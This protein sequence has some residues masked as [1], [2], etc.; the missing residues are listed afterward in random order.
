MDFS[1]S[2]T[3]WKLIES[4]WVQ[5]KA[6]HITCSLQMNLPILLIKRERGNILTVVTSFPWKCAL[7]MKWVRNLHLSMKYHS[8]ATL[9]LYHRTWF[10]NSLLLLNLSHK[11]QAY[12]WVGL[13]I[14][15][16][17]QKFYTFSKVDSERKKYLSSF[18]FFFF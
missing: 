17:S 13:N 16:K 4:S 9:A 5:F 1:S 14:K 11:W 15:E 18:H 12:P 3:G 7:T 2:H 6:Y 10:E 8:L